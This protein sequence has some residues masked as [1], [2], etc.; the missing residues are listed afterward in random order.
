MLGLLDSKDKE[1]IDSLSSYLLGYELQPTNDQQLCEAV[2]TLLSTIKQKVSQYG[3]NYLET[4]RS[5]IDSKT[6]SANGRFQTY[7]EV[8]YNFLNVA[9]VVDGNLMYKSNDPNRY[10]MQN[11]DF[12]LTLLIDS[13]QIKI[14]NITQPLLDDK[15]C[16][17]LYKRI[18]AVLNSII[19]NFNKC[20]RQKNNNNYL[21]N[22]KSNILPS[23]TRTKNNLESYQ[24]NTSYLSDQSADNTITLEGYWGDTPYISNQFGDNTVKTT[25]T[26]A[27][28]TTER[29]N[30]FEDE[31]INFIKYLWKQYTS[32]L[33]Y[34]SIVVKPNGSITPSE[35]NSLC[36]YLLQQSING[37]FSGTEQAKLAQISSAVGNA[38]IEDEQRQ[39]RVASCGYKTKTYTPNTINS[40]AKNALFD[41]ELWKTDIKPHGYKTKTYTPNTYTITNTGVK[42]GKVVRYIPQS[43]SYY[44]PYKPRQL[45]YTYQQPTY[46]LVQYPQTYS[47]STI[48]QPRSRYYT[49]YRHKNNS[50]NTVSPKYITRSAP[51]PT[52]YI[53][54][55]NCI[56]YVP[57]NISLVPVNNY[58]T[59]PYTYY[60]H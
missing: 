2:I 55:T 49:P 30:P 5:R 14:N 52:N 22:T 50:Q 53:T 43:F 1:S 8:L 42:S 38:Y 18:D 20:Y 29:K 46:N 36:N 28:S 58:Q 32:H 4:L 6:T 45:T 48:Q 23:P 60:S 51:T 7:G 11:Y 35:M 9:D 59:V 12:P 3:V 57:A 34:K 24:T 21:T 15:M 16:E 41:N 10:V 25:T 33:H 47:V 56:S 37:I 27:S 31:D 54:P 26:K 19:T 44:Q 17:D 39:G 13:E 40:V